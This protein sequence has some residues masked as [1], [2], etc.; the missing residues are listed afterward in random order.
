MTLR[1]RRLFKDIEMVINV[2]EPLGLS[3]RR[4][5]RHVKQEIKNVNTHMQKVNA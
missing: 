3:I 4:S 5:T 1:G 2:I